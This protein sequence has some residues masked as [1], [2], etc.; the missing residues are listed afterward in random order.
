MV[1]E[2][3]KCD[4]VTIRDHHMVLIPNYRTDFALHKDMVTWLPPT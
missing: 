3:C 2:F 1:H 4:L